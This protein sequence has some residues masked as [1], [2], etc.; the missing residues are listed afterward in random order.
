MGLSPWSAIREL[1][2]SPCKTRYFA[3]WIPA[4]S[5]TTKFFTIN[6]KE[7]YKPAQLRDPPCTRVHE[8]TGT[9]L[10]NEPHKGEQVCVHV[11]AGLSSGSSACFELRGCNYEVGEIQ[12]E[13]YRQSA[14]SLYLLP[15][16][17]EIARTIIVVFNETFQVYTSFRTEKP[18]TE[19]KESAKA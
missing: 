1:K 2:F 5:Y 6:S 16:Y 14:D 12:G 9:Y 15:L 19:V 11:R 17:A 8:F 10:A 13:R 18:C 4:H 3:S 7:G